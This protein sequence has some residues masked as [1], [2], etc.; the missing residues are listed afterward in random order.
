M[1]KNHFFV[2]I[3]ELLR[4]LH[5][6]MMCH[7]GIFLAIFFFQLGTHMSPSDTCHFSLAFV[8]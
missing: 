5:I 1:L 4:Q 3:F 2:V 6:K 8:C 7:T